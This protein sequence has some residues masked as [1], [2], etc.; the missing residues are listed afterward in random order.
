MPMG[1]ADIPQFET[2]N[3][4]QVNVFGYHNG[5]FFPLKISS[6]SSDFVMDLL[7]MYDCDHHH[8]VFITNLVKVVCYV[9][10]LDYRFS[11]KICRNCFWICREGLKSYNLHLKSKCCKNAPALIHMPS[12]E[13]NS[14]KF[15]DLAATWFV[16][17]FIFFDFELFLRPVSFAR[18]QVIKPY[19]SQGDTRSVWL[20][21]YSDRS[22]LIKSNLPSCRQFSCLHDKFCQN[23]SQTRQRN[24][25][26]E[27]EA[28]FIQMRLTKLLKI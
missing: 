28:P 26:A 9:R 22:P 15:T 6:C 14:Y 25:S 27:K 4:V 18:D 21:A 11:Y 5:Q 8:Y 23:A 19:T 24:L 1:I 10:G 3:N 2:L 7:L 12:S 13:N 16:P 17:L 20:C